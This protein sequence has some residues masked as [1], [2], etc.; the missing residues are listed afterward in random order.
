MKRRQFLALLGVVAAAPLLP[1]LKILAFAEAAP[2]P[3]EGGVITLEMLQRAF[4]RCSNGYMGERSY[5]VCSTTV[6]D[7]YLEL[8]HEN[9]RL[10][11]GPYDD[12][13]APQVTWKGVPVVDETTFSQMSHKYWGDGGYRATGFA[14]VGVSNN[15]RAIP[16]RKDCSW[17]GRERWVWGVHC[18]DGA[19]AARVS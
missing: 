11:G 7:R 2:P 17:P 1:P 19:R 4:N 3:S 12:A 5:L 13:W 9:S 8:L 6:R 14:V 10:I 18:G 15:P 16:L